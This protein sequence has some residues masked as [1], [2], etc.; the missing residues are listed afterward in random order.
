ME[1]RPTNE[2]LVQTE[3][4]DVLY[5]DNP[6]YKDK[7]DKKIRHYLKFEWLSFAKAL[8]QSV[9]KSEE[10][11]QKMVEESKK[12]TSGAEGNGADLGGKNK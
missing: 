9:G 1:Q 2:A 3:G 7:I 8:S 5:R 6:E 11:F 10:E 4:D 12:E